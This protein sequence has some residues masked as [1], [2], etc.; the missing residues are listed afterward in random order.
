MGQTSS[1]DNAQR[2]A[3]Q[4]KI[5]L[6]AISSREQLDALKFEDLTWKQLE[7]GRYPY[8]GKV[9][10]SKVLEALF[11]EE[12]AGP[13]YTKEQLLDIIAGAN[14]IAIATALSNMKNKSY[15]Y[16]DKPII[17]EKVDGKYVRQH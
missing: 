15:R 1:A 7:R 11:R 9:S 10:V 16:T 12:Y 14:W 2:W 17:I 6:H 3:L 13:S 4:S 8:F 5:L